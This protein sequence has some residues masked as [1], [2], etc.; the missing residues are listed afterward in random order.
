MNVYFDYAAT[1]PIDPQVFERMKPYQTT[2]FGNP[3][4]NHRYGIQAKN[5]LENAR[6][7]VNV[8]LKTK[9]DLGKVVFT[10]GGTESNVLAIHGSLKANKDRNEIIVSEVEHPSVIN[11]CRILEK[12]GYK[13]N[14]LP[15]LPNGQ[16]NQPELEPYLSEKT[17]LISLQYGNSETGVLF[18][19][20]KNLIK[21]LKSTQAVIH[22]DAC[23]SAGYLDLSFLL[24][25]ADLI[26]LSSAKIFGPQGV[27]C[28]FV[29][30]GVD[31][32]PTSYGGGQEFGLRSG[33][34]NVAGIVGFA[35]ALELISENRDNYYQ[36]AISLRKILEKNI[37]DSSQI[38]FSHLPR[39]PHHLSVT[40]P[41]LVGV[42]IVKLF[43]QAGFAVSSGSAC[44]NNEI[45][46]TSILTRYGLSLQE[47]N[48]T[49]RISFGRS[50]TDQEISRLS[51]FIKSLSFSN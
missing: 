36:Q 38:N 43:D 29:K 48:Q 28:L 1:T 22:I 34:Q 42:N 18:D 13:I 5:A 46:S 9:K 20:N 32:F 14:Y 44:S 7:S 16:I 27:G 31:I 19:F 23:Q 49:V 39:L 6:E 45:K 3:S 15:I 51:Q 26:T 21:L 41:T 4:S 12:Q 30:E 11:S 2:L 17:A 10:S 40:F 35:S 8:F 24:E 47:S 37:K 25:F 33:T 50:T